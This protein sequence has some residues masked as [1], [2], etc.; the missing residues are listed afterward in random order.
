MVYLLVKHEPRSVVPW[1]LNFDPYPHNGTW[2]LTWHPCLSI[3]GILDMAWYGWFCTKFIIQP[4]NLIQFQSHKNMKKTLL[5]FQWVTLNPISM[6]FMDFTTLNH[7]PRIFNHQ[8]TPDP[9][10]SPPALGSLDSLG[11]RARKRKAARMRSCKRPTLGSYGNRSKFRCQKYEGF[12]PKNIL[13]DQRHHFLNEK[14]IHLGMKKNWF[15]YYI[16]L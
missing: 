15:Y 4:F 12:P 16:L 2:M 9:D 3:F 11:S 5:W 10:P 14:K 6:P 1:V 13:A 7:E 8:L